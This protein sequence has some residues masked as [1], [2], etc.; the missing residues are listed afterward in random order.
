M[1]DGEGLPSAS[2]HSL[3]VD[4]PSLH[5]CSNGYIK[6]L[7]LESGSTTRL[8]Q[9]LMGLGF[10][11]LLRFG[12]CEG[13]LLSGLSA[14]HPACPEDIIPPHVDSATLVPFLQSHHLCPRQ[15]RF[16]MLATERSPNPAGALGL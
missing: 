6:A 2:S 12:S 8:G 5:P 15:G 3:H 10:R 14:G 13:T 9:F 16:L 11:P 1:K 7:Y 4:A